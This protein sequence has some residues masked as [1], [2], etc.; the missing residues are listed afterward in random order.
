MSGQRRIRRFSLRRQRTP[1][2]TFSSPTGFPEEQFPK[3][4]RL[5]IDN[6]PQMD[7]ARDC[8]GIST[9]DLDRVYG[10]E[11]QRTTVVQLGRNATLKTWEIDSAGQWEDWLQKVRANSLKTLLTK[12][13][14]EPGGSIYLSPRKRASTPLDQA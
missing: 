6:K 2:A 5:I 1:A 9:G 3:S 8:A 10:Y 14:A 13:S 7:W 12:L 11:W 4:K